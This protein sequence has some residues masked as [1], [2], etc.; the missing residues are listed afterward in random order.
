MTRPINDETTERPSAGLNRRTVLGGALAGGV[1]L[2]TVRHARAQAAVDEVDVVVIGAGFAGLTAALGVAAAGRSVRL[3]EARDRVGGRVLNHPIEG[4]RM[5]E[6]GGQFIGPTQNRMLE[7]SQEF[8]IKTYPTYGEGHTVSVIN[9]DRRIGDA[10]TGPDSEFMKLAAQLDAMAAEVPVAAPWTAPRVDEW[11]SI[12]L[13]SWVEA[14]TTNAETL[15]LFD[16]ISDLWGANARDVSLLFAL[17]YIAAAGDADTPGSLTRLLAIGGG[18]QEQRFDGGSQVLA[19]KMAATLGDELILSAPVRRISWSDSGVEVVT[20]GGSILGR[21]AIVAVPPGLAAGIQFEPPLPTLRRQLLQRLPMG[22]LIKI[23][24][25][26]DRPFWRD[27]GLSGVSV[28]IGTAV[29]SSF[30][31]SLPGDDRGIILGFVGGENAR[32]WAEL[33]EAARR[34]DAL[35]S[36]ASILGDEALSPVDFFIQDWPADPWTGGGPVALAAPGVLLSYGRAIRG[37]VGP[38]HWAGTETATYWIG[39][40]EGAVQS[41]D[42][43]AAEVLA[44]LAR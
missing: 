26:Y 3:I 15:G 13:R 30:D 24:A 42:R 19:E 27:A 12:T 29:R 14:N 7:L 44:A 11:D 38:L 10:D 41:G 4:G 6:A 35:A 40:M 34:D 37:P 32:S 39:Y 36:L 16:G 2:G 23:T 28:N 18:A 22:S 31:N 5:I 1:A 17:Y 8:G 25:I 21:Q 43:A 20:D 33:N 9:G